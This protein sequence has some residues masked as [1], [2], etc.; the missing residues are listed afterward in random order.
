[1]ITLVALNAV[2]PLNVT[3]TITGSDTR[4]SDGEGRLTLVAGAMNLGLTTKSFAQQR[5]TAQ[6][7]IYT[8]EPATWLA[9]GSALLALGVGRT[10]ARRKA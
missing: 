3:V 4:G 2:N 5:S 9:A 8:P 1:M 6:L 10:I 7:L